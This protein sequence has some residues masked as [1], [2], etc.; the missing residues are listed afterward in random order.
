[1][2][3]PV[4]PF[5][6]RIATHSALDDQETLACDELSLELYGDTI[7]EPARPP[8]RRWLGHTMRIASM[9][10]RISSHSQAAK[11]RG[12]RRRGLTAVPEPVVELDEATAEADVE[13]S[14]ASRA[15][16]FKR[17]LLRLALD[18]HDGPM[19][20]LTVIGLSLNDLKRRM[21]TI[22]ADE[23]HPRI[24]ASV[25]QI[26]DELVQVEQELRALISALED[27]AAQNIPLLDAIETEIREFKRLS[28]ANVELI[29]D[30]NARAET[31]S[32]RI[33]LQ[34]IAR[35]ALTNAAKHADP[36]N[37]QIRLQGTPTSVTL[38]VTD[39]GRG[40]IPEKAS[41]PGHFGLAG[42][43]ERVEMLGGDFRIKSRPG[44][45]TVVTATLQSW[46][47]PQA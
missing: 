33:A 2:K 1:V 16:T 19:Q 43:R 26:T 29:F 24:N 27:G 17:R 3:R 45:P 42:M 8:G 5:R 37:V 14:E 21:H 15:E 47:P 40:F 18:V 10:P 25:E 38:E 41:K 23:H 22:A 4:P 13:A 39:D 20:N 34:A 12:L 9:I 6:N 31:D 46:R 30:G 36:K 32:Q 44:G 11:H 7:V 35:A 28:T